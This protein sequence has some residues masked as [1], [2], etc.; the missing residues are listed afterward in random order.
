MSGCCSLMGLCIGG[1]VWV[2]RLMVGCFLMC[3]CSSGLVSCLC[4]CLMVWLC[5]GLLW[6]LVGLCVLSWV[7][8]CSWVIG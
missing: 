6:G 3:C 2:G 5:I 8:C 7:R 4:L 1:W